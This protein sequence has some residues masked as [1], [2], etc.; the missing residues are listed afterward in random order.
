[1][2]SY[3]DSYIRKN[4]N[5]R[6]FT[7]KKIEAV[8]KLTLLHLGRIIVSLGG[9][10]ETIKTSQINH[11]ST[12]KDSDLRNCIVGNSAYN[13][14]RYLIPQVII[15]YGR[16]APAMCS[17]RLCHPSPPLSRIIT[18]CEAFTTCRAPASEETIALFQL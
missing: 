15:T 3:S 2:I 9:S 6:N 5:L 4:L 17:Q 8:C 12:P 16:G 10:Q 18:S 1:M 14:E 13:T 7:L 11:L